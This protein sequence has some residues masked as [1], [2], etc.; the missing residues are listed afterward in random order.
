MENC[1]CS[2]NGFTACEVV[3]IILSI[4]A[5]VAVGI[6]FSSALIPAIADFIIIALIL[7]AITLVIGFGTLFSANTIK[8]C[9]AFYKC[10]CKFA[11]FLFTG[12]IGTILAGTIALTAGLITT[13]IVSIIFVALTA[14]FFVLM[15]V[16]IIC[17]VS[18]LISRTCEDKF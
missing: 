2:K 18:C 16:A 17:L 8:G 13:A 4:I 14:F 7:S 9:N 15:I 6:L 12:I 11:R 3:G 10:T 1:G 5:G